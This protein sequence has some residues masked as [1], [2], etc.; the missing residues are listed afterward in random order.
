MC[1]VTL[2][3]RHRVG[4]ENAENGGS[5]GDDYFQD[6]VPDSCTFTHILLFLSYK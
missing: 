1:T 5:Y 4:S 6:C 3:E 2:L